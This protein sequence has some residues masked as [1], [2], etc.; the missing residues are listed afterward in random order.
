MKT[1]SLLSIV[2]LCGSVLLPG[3]V[4]A[5]S[6]I[7]QPAHEREHWALRMKAQKK[8]KQLQYV[9]AGRLMDDYLAKWKKKP[10]ASRNVEQART[11]RAHFR[12]M[13]NLWDS[14]RKDHTKHLPALVA[15]T[16]KKRSFHYPRMS[17]QEVEACF[18]FA[19]EKNKGLQDKMHSIFPAKL[20]VA[21]LDKSEVG[22][23]NIFKMSLAESGRARSFQ[24]ESAKGKTR[25]KIRI[26]CSNQGNL[27]A[28]GQSSMVSVKLVG[29][30]QVID[31]QGKNLARFSERA[32]QVGINPE[33]AKMD[34]QRK[35]AKKIVFKLIKRM[36]TEAFVP[37]LF[38]SGE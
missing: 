6:K 36:M 28:F 3:V 14:A 22:D 24:I 35:L 32:A 31:G 4:G 11:E 37:R 1:N 23:L 7:E 10:E 16:L 30:V 20:D 18:D 29:Q 2:F 12:N 25:I 27:A 8:A 21:V 19:M 17:E 13:Q 34:A 33:S 9:E 15:E 5:R 26:F 38:K